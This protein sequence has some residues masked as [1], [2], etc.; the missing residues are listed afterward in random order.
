MLALAQGK[1]W[2]DAAADG[3]GRARLV[4]EETI[5]G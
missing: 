5:C 3:D 2:R 4:V 1:L